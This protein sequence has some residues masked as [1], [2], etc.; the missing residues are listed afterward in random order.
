MDREARHRLMLRMLRD[1]EPR[2][3]A[4]FLE[5]LLGGVGEA[6]AYGRAGAS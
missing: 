6:R 4:P 1:A 2:A 3:L 5:R